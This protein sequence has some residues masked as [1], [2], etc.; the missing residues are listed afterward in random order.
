[1]PSRMSVQWSFTIAGFLGYCSVLL[2]KAKQTGRFSG[3]K[4]KAAQ[5]QAQ[6]EQDEMLVDVNPDFHTNLSSRSWTESLLQ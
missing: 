6:K 5:E 4:V 1:M 2:M 3:L